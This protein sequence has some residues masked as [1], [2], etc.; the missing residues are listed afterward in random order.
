MQPPFVVV[1][2]PANPDQITELESEKTKRGS[3]L[4]QILCALTQPEVEDLSEVE[5]FDAIP[6][7]EH[8]TPPRYKTSFLRRM[9]D[10]FIKRDIKVAL[11]EK[12]Y[13]A[14][15]KRFNEGQDQLNVLYAR[16]GSSEVFNGSIFTRSAGAFL[17]AWCPIPL[18]EL[19][20]HLKAG[21]QRAGRHKPP[22]DSSKLQS[23]AAAA[24]GGFSNAAERDAFIAANQG[25]VGWVANG[26]LDRGMTREEL[27]SA[28]NVGLLKAAAR[29]DVRKGFKFSTYAVWWI[30]G[31]IKHEFRRI[32]RL[33][34]SD[35][36]I[37]RQP[38]R[39]MESDEEETKPT[40][41][42]RSAE[43]KATALRDLPPIIDSGSGEDVS[44]EW[45][46]SEDPIEDRSPGSGRGVNFVQDTYTPVLEFDVERLKQPIEQLEPR[47]ALVV[48]MRLGLDGHT[49]H[50]FKEI[51]QTLDIS[52]QRAHKI[53]ETAS[54]RLKEMV[55]D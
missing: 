14:V 51:G 3:R 45:G 21:A 48:R 37:L 55:S 10:L 19:A 31:E 25:L 6:I 4:A 17:A 13:D 28:G 39:L 35:K 41:Q 18:K 42:Q 36:A 40:S 5:G 29:F 50:T 53:F 7:Q 27:V 24:S 43:D 11:L 15:V 32:K 30:E 16:L 9:H 1:P 2:P 22:F 44:A 47:D 52:T 34:V 12:I 23:L 20:E 33:K 38:K 54:K 46:G 8:F 49:Q 26:Y